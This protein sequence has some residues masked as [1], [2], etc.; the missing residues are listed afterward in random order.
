[1][2]S[3]LR[4]MNEAARKHGFAAMVCDASSSGMT[5]DFLWLTIVRLLGFVQPICPLANAKIVNSYLPDSRLII[6]DGPGVRLIPSYP[7]FLSP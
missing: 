6:Q 4:K 1:M 3:L 5:S 2:N 7:F